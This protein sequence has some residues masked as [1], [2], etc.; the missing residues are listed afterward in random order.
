MPFVQRDASG[1]IIA[2]SGARTTACTEAVAV[3]DPALQRFLGALADGQDT[4]HAS[5]QDL[6]RVLEDL[7]DLLVAK[8][9]ILFTELPSSAQQKIMQRQRLRS[10]LGA[11]LDLIGDD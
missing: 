8:G 9:V 3:S 11:A 6:V 5:D 1:E 2:V 4:L 7:V 10:E